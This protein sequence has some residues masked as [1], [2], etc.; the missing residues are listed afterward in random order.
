MTV[1]CVISSTG[2]SGSPTEVSPA[3]VKESGESAL[4]QHFSWR[5]G[6]DTGPRS[7]EKGWPYLSSSFGLEESQPGLQSM[8][9]AERLVLLSLPLYCS[10]FFFVC[11]SQLLASSLFFF[12]QTDSL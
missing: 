8:G 12:F 11:P 4:A 10:A 6:A 5:L 2:W 9:R 7:R 3:W 1:T